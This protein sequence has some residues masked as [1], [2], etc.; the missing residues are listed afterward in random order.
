MNENSCELKEVNY[1]QNLGNKMI[2]HKLAETIWTGVHVPT[3]QG[4]LIREAA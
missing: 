2:A 4:C 3:S 1:A